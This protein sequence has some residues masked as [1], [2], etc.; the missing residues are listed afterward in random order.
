MLHV[1]A[2]TPSFVPFCNRYHIPTI[3]K[4]LTEVGEEAY[5]GADN[6]LKLKSVM[7]NTKPYDMYNL[8]F[9]SG[10]VKRFL[11]SIIELGTHQ[12][13]ILL[14][15]YSRLSYSIGAWHML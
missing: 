8:M 12:H 10:L 2:L 3:R 6:E 1:S 14:K 9:T 4:T 13:S 11:L 7:M 15:R 5:L